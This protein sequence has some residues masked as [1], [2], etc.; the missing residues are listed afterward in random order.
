MPSGIAK[1]IASLAIWSIIRM[2]LKRKK[3]ILYDSGHS[4]KNNTQFW[5]RKHL[6]NTDYIKVMIWVTQTYW[7]Y[8]HLGQPSKKWFKGCDILFNVLI[9]T[10]V[11]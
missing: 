7:W 4:E 2:E 9:R 10:E 1:T 8:W 3:T 6:L 5:K 11:L